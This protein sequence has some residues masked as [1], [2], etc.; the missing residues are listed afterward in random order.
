MDDESRPA[1][2]WFRT[3]AAILP[4]PLPIEKAIA[5]VIDCG[6]AAPP[7]DPNIHSPVLLA[8]YQEQVEKNAERR[9]VEWIVNAYKSIHADSTM[10]PGVSADIRGEAPIRLFRASWRELQFVRTRLSEWPGAS[11]SRQIGSGK[12]PVWI[13]HC[14]RDWWI[15]FRFD[16]S[17]FLN[18][19]RG[20]LAGSAQTVDK[21]PPR[22]RDADEID[23]KIAVVLKAFAASAASLPK[24]T[25]RTKVAEDAAKSAEVKATGYKLPTVKKIMYST[26]PPMKDRGISHPPELQKLFGKA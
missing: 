12:E 9:A 6:L 4:D 19:L 14:G 1:D 20:S 13:G 11:L 21:F 16:R 3:A 7:S 24:G 18:L 5:C 8:A 10:V 17:Q 22:Q 15:R 2:R 25:S 23:R 26:F